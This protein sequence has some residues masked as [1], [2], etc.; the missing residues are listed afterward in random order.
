MAASSSQPTTAITTPHITHLISLKLTQENYLLWH[1]Q[2]ILILRTND[3]LGYVCGTKPCPK[4][5]L[6]D[7]NGKHTSTIN[8]EH[9]TLDE[10]RFTNLVLDQLNS[11]RGGGL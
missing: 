11:V 5:F 8:P 1:A 9:S 4:E 10:T 7:S 3:L 2:I 6:C